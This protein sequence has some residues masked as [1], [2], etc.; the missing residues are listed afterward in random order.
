MTYCFG[1]KYRNSVYLMADSAVTRSSGGPSTPASSFG[2]SSVAIP[3]HT[4]DEGALKIIRVAADCLV[5]YSGDIRRAENA[6]TTLRALYAQAD[7][8]PS[9][10]SRLAS[11]IDVRADGAFA[12]LLARCTNDGPEL[13]K[14]ESRSPD[15]APT[16][17]EGSAHIGSLATWHADLTHG[18]A[19]L[20]AEGSLDE[21]RVLVFL[22]A[23]IQGFGLRDTLMQHGVGGVI[24]AAQ[25]GPAGATWLPDVNYVLHTDQLTSFE[26][27]SVA[28]RADGVAV[29]SSLTNDTRAFLSSTS[30]VDPGA[31]RQLWSGRLQQQFD[32]CGARIWVFLG[33]H[34]AT[35]F[36][37]DAGSVVTRTPV[38]TVDAQGNG[39]FKFGVHPL[40]E[41]VLRA[42][43]Q[44]EPG[45]MGLR[46]SFA[47]AESALASLQTWLT[48]RA[49]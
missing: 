47:R 14:W 7:S 20:I 48:P 3:G 4:V 46:V 41:A 12:F 31:W 28:C 23:L 49:V 13:W 34:A 45:T 15:A 22:T 24:S 25:V 35:I 38:C 36:I 19:Q 39:K 21:D 27:I 42:P 16:L 8:V 17:I 26:V 44:G 1:L 10:F 37:L 6:A 9:L 11:S 33:L 40:L 30:T 5:A 18:M 2:E 43:L 29:C 32:A